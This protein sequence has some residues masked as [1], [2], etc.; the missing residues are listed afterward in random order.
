MR[1]V[2]RNK[3]GHSNS[4]WLWVSHDS[5]GI[6]LCPRMF[7]TDSPGE[8]TA[9][10][11]RHTAVLWKGWGRR[12]RGLDC[13]CYTHKHTH[14]HAHAGDQQ[15]AWMTHEWLLQLLLHH[16]SCVVSPAPFTLLKNKTKH[17]HTKKKKPQK[18]IKLRL[19]SDCLWNVGDYF[20]SFLFF[21]T[22]WKHVSHLFSSYLVDGLKNP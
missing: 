2:S 9:G 16:F 7:L 1:S 15:L 20:E 8:K 6:F 19:A 3:R 18:T 4:S 13:C 21:V 17:R 14:P 5:E 12:G 22:T 11:G 10:F